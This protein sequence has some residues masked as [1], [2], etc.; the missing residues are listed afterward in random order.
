MIGA[1][2]TRKSMRRDYQ[3][4]FKKSFQLIDKAIITDNGK[5]LCD[6]HRVFSKSAS[7]LITLWLYCRNIYHVKSRAWVGGSIDVDKYIIF[8]VKHKQYS[9]MPVYQE[10]ID[11]I[12]GILAVKDLLPL[13]TTNSVTGF[14]L[15]PYIRKPF[16]VPI[17][18]K[19]DVLL[20]SMQNAKTP[21]RWISRS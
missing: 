20:L 7:P 10:H 5:E 13:I 12:I 9:R 8:N 16:F 14:S 11:N 19:I 4:I 17:K 2:V 18:K 1:Q 15:S 21:S 3:A 6:Y